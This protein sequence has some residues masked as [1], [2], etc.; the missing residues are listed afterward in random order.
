MTIES[1]IPFYYPLLR[2]RKVELKEAKVIAS[3]IFK[4]AELYKCP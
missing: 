3:I 2:F 4:L 1:T